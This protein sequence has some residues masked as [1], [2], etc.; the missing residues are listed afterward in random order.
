MNSYTLQVKVNEQW[1]DIGVYYALTIDD[2]IKLAKEDHGYL[3]HEW[4][5]KP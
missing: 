4:R 1:K 5:Q 3:N 2:A